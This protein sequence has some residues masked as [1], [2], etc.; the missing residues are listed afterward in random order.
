VKGKVGRP[1]VVNRGQC[2]VTLTRESV[3]SDQDSIK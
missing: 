1:T 3:N 2:P